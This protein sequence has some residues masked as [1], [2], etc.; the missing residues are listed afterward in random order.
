MGVC[1]VVTLNPSPYRILEVVESIAIDFPIPEN[2]TSNVI[3]LDAFSV[4]VNRIDPESESFKTMGFEFAPTKTDDSTDDGLSPDQPK[5]PE[6][7]SLS[8]PPSF[9]E[10]VALPPVTDNE[11]TSQPIRISNTVYQTEALFTRR[12]N[13]SFVVGSIIA[14]ATLSVGSAITR[15]SNLDPPIVLIFAKRPEVING[16]NVSCNFWDFSS[17]GECQALITL[18]LSLNLQVIKS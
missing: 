14:S 9:F 12:G 13:N 10:N 2:E 5:P 18:H 11:T 7:I 4:T 3:E 17:D 1:S 8:I 16:S 6:P 15:V